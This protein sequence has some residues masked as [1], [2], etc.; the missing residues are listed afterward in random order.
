MRNAFKI[1]IELFLLAGMACSSLFFSESAHSGS[2]ATKSEIR[3]PVLY[4]KSN[5]DEFL[6]PEKAGDGDM[7]PDT[8]I[9]EMVSFLKPLGPE[10]ILVICGNSDSKEKNK[11]QLTQKRITKVKNLLI[12]QG[13]QGSRIREK[14]QVDSLPNKSEAVIQETLKTE[15]QETAELFRSYNRTVYFHLIKAGDK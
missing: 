9:A 6:Y 3:I 14:N 2:S 15:G 12:Q 1:T 4:F 5:S 8:I 10:H 11:K 7:H 13:V